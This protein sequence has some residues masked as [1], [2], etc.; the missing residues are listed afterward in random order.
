MKQKRRWF[1][2]RFLTENISHVSYHK[3]N[4]V[5]NFLIGGT[6]LFVG[7][8]Q[9]GTATNA[10]VLSSEDEATLR[11]LKTVLWS[12]AYSEQDTTLLNQILHEDFQL[13]DDNGDTYS[14]QDEVEYIAN[15]GPSYSEFEF[16]IER[17]DLFENGT[18]MVSGTGI[19]KGENSD[20]VYIT[21]YKSS[22]AFIKVEGQWKAINSHVS[23]VKEETFGAAPED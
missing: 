22:N 9:A 19:M 1:T 10:S 11:D 5:L 21:K 17:I 14:K 16:Q 4:I 13:V 6:L 20:G 18:A 15:Y 23:G 8:N 2:L 3:L 7:C 12:R